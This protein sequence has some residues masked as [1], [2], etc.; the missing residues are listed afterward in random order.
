MLQASRLEQLSDQL[1]ILSSLCSVLGIDLKDKIS[2]IYPSI[3]ST[4]TNDVS[5]HALKNL[6]SEVQS[7]REVK[8]QRIK[9]VSIL[10][11]IFHLVKHH[12]YFLI[13]HVIY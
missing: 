2:E 11:H 6:T 1:D 10:A 4:V 13:F 7:L 12:F 5:D 3:T 8:I 9:K